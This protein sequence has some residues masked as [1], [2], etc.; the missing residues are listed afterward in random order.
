MIRLQ[1]RRK[2]R[3]DIFSGVRG[4]RCWRLDWPDLDSGA[5][6]IDLYIPGSERSRQCV[7]LWRVD[8]SGIDIKTG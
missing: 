4:G 5:K 7:D 8:L 2:N 3:A 6:A 1:Q